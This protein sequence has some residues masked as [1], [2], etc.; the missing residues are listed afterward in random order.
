MAFPPAP[1]NYSRSANDKPLASPS[2]GK[3]TRGS[4]KI[5]SKH[6]GPK[7]GGLARGDDQ[8]NPNILRDGVAH[9]RRNVVETRGT[10]HDIDKSI[11]ARLGTVSGKMVDRR[12]D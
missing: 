6:A 4:E 5:L 12:E 2:N 10:S 1:K 8:E 3:E 9:L 7:S 11:H